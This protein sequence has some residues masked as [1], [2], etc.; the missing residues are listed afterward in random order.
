MPIHTTIKVN[1]D[2][3]SHIH[4]TRVDDNMS[5]DENAVLEYSVIVKD[6][7]PSRTSYFRDEAQEAPSWSEWYTEGVRFTHRYGDG[8][9]VCVQKAL[10][11]YHKQK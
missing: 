10:E 5:M 8:V 2:V 3:I 7:N 4:I 6:E 9:L 1:Q 11:A